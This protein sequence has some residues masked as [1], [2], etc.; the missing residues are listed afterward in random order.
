MWTLAKSTTV[1]KV[2]LQKSLDDLELWCSIWR[3]KLNVAKT[4]LVRFPKRRDKLELK[5]FGQRIAE[6]DDLT[7]LGVTFDQR[8]SFSKHCRQ[9]AKEAT[10]RVG[11]LKRVSGQ[12]WG[13]SK[14]VLLN[15]Y[16]QYVR[17]V[18]ETGSAGIAVGAKSSLALLQRVQ[19]S[20]LRTSLRVSRRTR[21]KKLHR[22]ARMVPIPER[23]R[24]LQDKAVARFKASP[25]MESLRT[26]Q[27]L[28]SKPDKRVAGLASVQT[29]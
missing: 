3:I 20:A 23:L 6:Q 29:Q 11:L 25:L 12:R 13:A 5:L 16:K 17:P 24:S 9:K 26:Q 10:R 18:M 1:A 7:L 4:Q 8:L 19:N 2:R 22:L 27:M 28:L 21:I 15:L 14:R